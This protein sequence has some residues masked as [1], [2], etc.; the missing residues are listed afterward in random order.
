MLGQKGGRAHL[1]RA[2]VSTYWVPVF[3]PIAV[4]ISYRSRCAIGGKPA[5]KCKL[6]K[7]NNIYIYFSILLI[8]NLRGTLALMRSRCNVCETSKPLGSYRIAMNLENLEPINM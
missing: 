6:A 7:M 5:K 8:P 4:K 1:P 2:F 3:T